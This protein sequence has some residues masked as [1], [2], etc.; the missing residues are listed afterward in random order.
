MLGIILHHVVV[1]CIFEI[2]LTDSTSIKILDNALFSH[3]VF[4]RKLIPLEFAM[5]L[6]P[7][8]NAIFIL[9]S[10]YFLINK[11]NRFSVKNTAIKLLT[12]LLFAALALIIVPAVIYHFYKE[13][14]MSLPSTGMFNGMSWFIGYYFAVALTASL[15]LNIFLKK[16][17]KEQYSTVLLVVFAFL[18]FSW[19]SNLLNGLL[20]DAKTYATGCF[21]YALGGYIQLYNPF[22]KIR[23]AVLIL[24]IVGIFGIIALG[25]HS[26]VITSI[27]NY[28]RSE[29][30]DPFVQPWVG[31]NN[32]SIET[33]LLALCTFE[34]FRRLSIPN[35]KVINFLGASTL[36]AYLVHDN[37]Y[38]YSLWETTDW[39][40]LIHDNPWSVYTSQLPLCV[41]FTFALGVICYALYLGCMKLFKKYYPLLLKAEK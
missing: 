14:Y 12:Q 30:T 34:L 41:L 21:L 3:P 31:F 29:S 6:G 37:S 2:Q 8:G 10:G 1:H 17:T 9:I 24:V 26:S 40:T 15:F 25:Y 13:E 23:P 22:E 16:L 35:N 11:P 32:T 39:I 4:Y 33:I 20:N 27:E 7:T 28:T 36:M 18:S 38:F 19:S 5:P